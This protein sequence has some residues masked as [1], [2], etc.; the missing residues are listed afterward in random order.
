MKKT[1]DI[2]VIGAGSGGLNIASFM[3]GVGFKTLLIDKSDEHIGGD[4]LNFGCV[5]SKALI[6]IARSI[7][8]GNI[9]KEFGMNTSGKIDMEKVMAY[10]RSR[11]EIIR[12]HE[13]VD[14]FS[15]KGMDVALG[16]ARFVGKSSVEVA[17]NVYY[18]KRIVVATGSKP[19]MIRFPGM[20]PVKFYTNETIFGL[21]KLPQ[22]LL[23]IGGGPI[24]IELGQAFL[25]MGSKVVVVNGGDR[26]LGKEDAEVSELMKE[27]LEKQGMEFRLNARL[28]EFPS[29]QKA[30]IQQGESNETIDFDTVLL[31][32]GR[33]ISHEELKPGAAGIKTEKGR[34][35]VD[36]YLR[37]TNRRVFVV[38]DAAGKHQ[39]THAA[40]LHARL[41]L[42]NFFSPLKKKLNTDH[43]SW[44]T[45][46]TP[47]VAT[48]G[49][50]ED[51][52][53]KRKISY[54]LQKVEFT[55]DDR[56]IVD[57]YRYGFLKVYVRKGELLGGTMVAPG[58]GE[59]FQELVLA[60]TLGIGI[61]GLFKKIY[62]Y[63]TA[64]RINMKMA[65]KYLSDKLTPF[66]KRLLR[67]LYRL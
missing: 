50:S 38:G 31:A 26:I 52:L 43:L 48:F 16:E 7:H 25:M 19:L 66:K 8:T 44:V 35:V 63:P 21:K 2:I 3:N 6:H 60:N 33:E 58:A 46:T 57:G 37:T 9:A 39:F 20:D 45:Y 29:A 14:Y 41:V 32:V 30:L 11:Q 65:G 18:G 40:E 67:A 24:G 49:L 27:R 12:K 42:R 47:E 1:Y 22:K 59:L 28:K 23:V 15:K 36:D 62:P 5:P 54:T 4:C 64:T 56:A 13:N 55:D 10:V 61:N 34:I 51:E 53:Q 17:G